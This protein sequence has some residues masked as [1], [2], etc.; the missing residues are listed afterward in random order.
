MSHKRISRKDFLKLGGAGLGA[1]ALG[2]IGPNLGKGLARAA[3][4]GDRPNILFI[5]VD[6]LHSFADLPAKLPLPTFRKLAREGRSFENYHVH[7]APCGP[8]RSVIYTGQHVQKTG[9]YSNPPGEDTDLP[10]NAHPVQLSPDFPTVGK[11]LRELGYYTAYKGKWH[12][13]LINQPARKRAKGDYPDTTDSLEPYGFS[14]YNFDGEQG[15]MTWVGFGHDGQFAADSVELLNNFAKGRTK[16]KPWFFALNF[17][18]P[19]DIMFYREPDPRSGDKKPSGRFVYKEPP[20]VPLYEKTW[21][22]PLPES[23][24]KDDL[25]TKP[26]VQRAQAGK[27]ALQPLTPGSIASWKEYQDYYFNCIRD[28]DRHI[29]LVL[30]SLE[31]FGFGENTIVI[32]TAD[33]GEMRGAHRLKGKGA[34]LYKE[35]LRVPLVVRHPKM[36]DGVATQALGGSVDLVPTILGY[37]G[38]NDAERAAKFPYL[39]GVDLHPVVLNASARTDRD[40]RGILFDYMSPGFGPVGGAISDILGRTLIRGVFDGRYKFGRYFRPAEH[41]IPKDWETLVAHNDLELYDTKT[42]PNELVNLALNAAENRDLILSL[43]DRVNALIEREIGDDNGSIYPGPVAQ[44]E[45]K[46]AG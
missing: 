34:Y 40:K 5:T 19:H 7:V 42:D 10:E 15:G 44:Y 22:F 29:S 30:D 8:S 21:D 45:L 6:Q 36:K 4:S 24:Y 23:L 12:L 28:V 38:V 16:G 33:H 26:A 37:A 18:N 1:A 11:M 25:S 32:L 46:S 39:N 13:S 20:L 14:D 17:I 31:R 41:H 43:N 2:A 35:C 3:E 9:M 27:E